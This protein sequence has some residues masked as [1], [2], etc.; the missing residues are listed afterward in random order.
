MSVAPNTPDPITAAKLE[1]W[2]DQSATQAHILTLVQRGNE[3]QAKLDAMQQEA[4]QKLQVKAAPLNLSLENTRKE[5]EQAQTAFAQRDAERN[6][7]IRALEKTSGR[8]DAS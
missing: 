5:I 8:N 1:H 6:A 4:Q 3:L 7:Y 2:E